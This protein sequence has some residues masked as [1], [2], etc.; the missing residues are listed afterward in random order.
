[1]QHNSKYYI[2]IIKNICMVNDIIYT[3]D[4]WQLLVWSLPGSYHFDYWLLG[5]ISGKINKI[6]ST[7]NYCGISF[8]TAIHHKLVNRI[9]ILLAEIS[10]TFVK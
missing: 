6:N 4:T 1:M 3:D 10:Y 7:T 9:E 2:S 8:D 5:W